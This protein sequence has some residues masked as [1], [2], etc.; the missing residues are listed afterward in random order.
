MTVMPFDDSNANGNSFCDHQTVRHPFQLNYSK[1]FSSLS[2][3]AFYNRISYVQY[4]TCD[5]HAVAICVH[6]VMK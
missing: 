2:Y 1:A 6:K 4:K 3:K 5:L